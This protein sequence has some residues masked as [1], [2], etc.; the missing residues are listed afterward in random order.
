MKDEWQTLLQGG[1]S[2][3][4][5]LLVGRIC[6]LMLS[7]CHVA[8]RCVSSTA[9][10]LTPFCL[11]SAWATLRAGNHL[12]REALGGLAGLVL[13][14]IRCQNCFTDSLLWQTRWW[15]RAELGSRETRGIL[16]LWRDSPFGLFLFQVSSFLSHLLVRCW[17]PDA[18]QCPTVLLWGLVKCK[19]A[20]AKNLGPSSRRDTQEGKVTFPFTCSITNTDGQALLT[21][22][23]E[24]RWGAGSGPGRALQ[25]EPSH[26]LC[27]LDFSY[28][29]LCPP[30]TPP[31]G[32]IYHYVSK[33]YKA[34]LYDHATE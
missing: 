22:G 32:L 18:I 31:V 33:S 25:R 24:T 5:G 11:C 7:V 27:S 2:C 34:S 21:L 14:M 20:K 15:R 28:V 6:L 19:T 30:Q 26:V 29:F 8:S 1:L 23:W 10:L 17:P 13:L 12:N 16:Q 4:V 3:P 9:V